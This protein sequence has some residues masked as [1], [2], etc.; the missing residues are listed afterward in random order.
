MF[1]KVINYPGFWKSM[2]LSSFVYGAAMYV[3]QWG[4]VNDWGEFFNEKTST[5]LLFFFS[6]VLVGFTISFAKF[7]RKIKEEERSK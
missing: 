2:A 1:K 3:F 7:Y 4:L 6:C 5:I